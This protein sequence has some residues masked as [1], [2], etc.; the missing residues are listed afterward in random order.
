[1]PGE[2]I[3]GVL[4]RRSGRS[5]HRHGAPDGRQGIKAHRELGR[6]VTDASGVL[7]SYLRR[8]IAEPQ[9]ELLVERLRARRSA[10]SGGWHARS[11]RLGMQERARLTPAET[12]TLP[13]RWPSNR[14]RSPTPFAAPRARGGCA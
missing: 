12:R 13:G 14:T 2:R 8:L 11:V 6:D 9:Q 7:R 1:R 4:A 3:V 5:E 10:L